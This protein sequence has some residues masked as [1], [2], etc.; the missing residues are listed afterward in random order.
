MGLESHVASFGGGAL[1]LLR[2]NNGLHFSS[3]KTDI[4]TSTLFLKIMKN[5]VQ[6]REAFEKRVRHILLTCKV[7]AILRLELRFW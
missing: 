6:S 1:L 5:M 7:V 2:G 3:K 4:I